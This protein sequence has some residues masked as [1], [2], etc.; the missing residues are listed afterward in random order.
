MEIKISVTFTVKYLSF[1]LKLF[2]W[3]S[4]FAIM[5]TL[6]HWSLDSYPIVIFLHLRLFLICSINIG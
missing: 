3:I 5:S 2:Y 4:D 6:I 1:N